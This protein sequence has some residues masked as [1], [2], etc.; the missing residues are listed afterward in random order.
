[1]KLIKFDASTRNARTGKTCISFGKKGL[2]SLSKLA[3][4]KL[5][6]KN[7]DKVSLFQDEEEADWYIG[8]DPK[9]G[10]PIRLPEGKGGG[11][12]LQRICAVFS[13]VRKLGVNNRR[14]TY[15]LFGSGA[16]KTR[17]ANFVWHLDWFCSI[18]L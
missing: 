18:N 8:K 5:E 17:K 16:N 15:F 14:N 7:G 3:V 12:I 10:F 1:M 11:G 13:A 9:D 4:E 6:L 2:I